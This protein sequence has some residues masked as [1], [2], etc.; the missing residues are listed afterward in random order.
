MTEPE[1]LYGGLEAGGTKWVC[2]VGAGPDDIRATT[3]FA[4]TTPQETIAQAVAFFSPYRDILAGLGIG[5]FG[6]LDLHPA[7]PTFGWITST[8]KPG[9]AQT[10]LVGALRQGLDVS[11]AFDTDVNAAAFGECHWGA[12]QSLDTFLY[13]TVGTGLGGGAIVNGQL[14][15][16][17]LHPEMGHLR[18]PHDWQA[19]AFAG[20]CPYH[21]DCL[22]GLAAGPALEARWGQAGETLPDDHPAWTLEAHYLALG[23]VA[24]ICTLMPQRIIMGGGVMRRSQLFPLIQR[25]V[26]QLLNGYIQAP[27]LASDIES[28][29]VPPT[30]GECAGVLGALALAMHQI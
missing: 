16:G 22:E 19:D 24:F 30:L 26:Q 5:C 1:P 15:H 27:E 20:T 23:L 14:L 3:R 21:G 12:A 2:A 13:M 28:Y 11:V 9:W 7:S 8:P 25:E 6:P 4:T 10:D 17:L 29:I 18:I